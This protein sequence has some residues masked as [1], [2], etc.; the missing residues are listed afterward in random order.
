VD[1]IEHEIES[2][3]N[4]AELT[5][6]RVGRLLYRMIGFRAM[7]AHLSE[8]TVVGAEEVLSPA[9]D[10]WMAAK[11]DLEWLSE[12][13]AEIPLEVKG[14]IQRFI[15]NFEDNGS[16]KSQWDGGEELAMRIY[17]R[18]ELVSR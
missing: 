5:W 4:G 15:G 10:S 13:A 12:N 2:V 8:S 7:E 6:F 17:R 9:K 18:L 16:L 14:Q 1:A 11:A 3:A